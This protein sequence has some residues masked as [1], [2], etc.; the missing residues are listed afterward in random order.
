MG[1]VQDSRGNVFYTDLKQVW[2]VAPDGRK[3][4]A[5][6][7]V[8]THELCIDAADNVFGEHLWYEGDATGKWGH[9]VWRL[10]PDGNVSDVI[11]AREGF[12]RDYSFVRDR[13]GNMYWAEHGAQAAIK[14]TSTDGK[15]QVVASGGFRDVRGMTAAPDGTVYLIDN[16]DLKRISPRGEVTTLVPRLSS[17]TP[18][19]RNVSDRHYHMGLWIDGDGHVHVAIAAEKTVVKVK[20][21]GTVSVAARSEGTWSPSGGLVDRGGRLWVLEYSETNAVRARRIEK[22]GKEKVF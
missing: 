13:A 15:T 22:D 4:V 10:K 1:I 20:R 6:P 12:L 18:P 16:G 11:P 7:N 9:R 3:S 19:P 8:H 14:K 17:R 2:R 21:D 5:V